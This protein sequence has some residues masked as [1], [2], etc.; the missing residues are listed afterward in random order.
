[1]EDHVTS[2]EAPETVRVFDGVVRSRRT[3][4]A[5]RPEPLPRSRVE[6]I[7]AVA[8]LAPSTF[9]TQPWRVHVLTGAPKRALSDAIARAHEANTEPAFS[10]FPNPAPT[11]C[12]ARQMDFGKR[13]YG[14]LKIDREDMA[15]RSRQTGRNFQFFDAPLGL[16]FTIDRALTQHSWLDCGLFIQTFMLA[17]HVRGISTCPQVSFVRYQRV[18][19]EQLNLAANEAV[20]CGMSMGNADEEAPV[21]Q[22]AMPR[23]AVGDFSSWLGF[24]GPFGS[25]F[26]PSTP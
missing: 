11:D 4:R 20:I 17:A 12:A 9:N 21:N 6:E 7:L 16:V 26:G 10:P 2:A 19:A 24:D 25:K 23:E 18:I 13:Y 14:A 3:V 8:R 15:A 1:M 22:C 5:F